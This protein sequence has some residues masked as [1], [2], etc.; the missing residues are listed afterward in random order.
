MAER[1]DLLA[2]VDGFGPVTLDPLGFRSG[3]LNT[4]L[5]DRYR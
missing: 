5:D 2:V 3:S 4:V 1:P